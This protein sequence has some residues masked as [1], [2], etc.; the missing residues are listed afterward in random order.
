MK[1]LIVGVGKLGEYL[2][3]CL[4]KEGN[5]VTLVDRDF[6]K[7]KDVINNED[8]AYICGNGLDTNI[9]SEAGINDTDLLIS[10]MEKDEQNVM[11]CML[12]KKLGAN[13]T[14]ARIRTP[15]Y[16][17]S[18]SILKDELGLS[19]IINPELLTARHI[20][21]ILSIPSVLDVTMFFK[22]RIE[23]ISLKVKEK[24]CLVGNTMSNMSKKINGRIIICAI[25]RNGEIIIPRGNTKVQVNDKIYV[26]GTPKDI[27]EF[28]KFAKEM[29]GQTKTVLIAGGSNTAIYLTKILEE[30]DM[31]VKIIEI[32]EDR[33]K[34]LSETLKNTLIINGDVSDQNV[35]YEEGI[36]KCDAFVT[37]NSIDEENIVCSIFA[38]QLNVPK[39]ITKVNHINL[40]GVIDTAKLDTIITPHKIA[41]NQIVRYVSAMQNSG[42]S[43]C[44][45]IYK[46]ADEKIEMLE[47]NI[48]DDFAMIDKKIKDLSLK[49]GIL[50]LAIW[51]GRKVIFPNGDDK[52][53]KMDTVI[54]INN[55][56]D[57]IKDINDILE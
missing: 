42:A 5:E 6:S 40:E 57:K 12:G 25:E 11:C 15:E 26:T 51:R 54:V 14:I 49:D 35:L 47:F 46:F 50:I 56:N 53:E 9:L 17:N 20:A 22:G 23:M 41:S 31:K 18:V 36:D 7:A 13:H 19:M 4:V 28:L 37:L 2:A 52:I 33:C 48:R 44:E 32:N 21:N 27:R 30:M 24:S 39:I 34:F 8:L 16:A 38:K 43:C 55:N 45:S 10:V 3:K 1:I 29:D